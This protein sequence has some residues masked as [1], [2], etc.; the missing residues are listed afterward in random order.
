MHKAYENIKVE[1]YLHEVDKTERDKLE[2]LLQQIAKL[3]LQKVDISDV[4]MVDDNG[5]QVAYTCLELQEDSPEY[6]LVI[7]E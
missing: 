7:T 4:S 6:D 2:R 1:V 3:L 5:K